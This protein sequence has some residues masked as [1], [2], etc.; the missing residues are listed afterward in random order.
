VETRRILI[1]CEPGLLAQGLSSLLE[2]DSRFQVLQVVGDAPR[3]IELIRELKPHVLLVEGERFPLG[4][5]DRPEALPL[6]CVPTVVLLRQNDNTIHIYRAETH[7]QTA[8]P[9]LLETLTA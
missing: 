3:A 4:L 7:T 1:L 5:G 8:L 2:A 9:D 6:E